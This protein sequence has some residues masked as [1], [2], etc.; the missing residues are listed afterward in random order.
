MPRSLLDIHRVQ[1]LC[2]PC[3]D[4]DCS[5]GLD[6]A[7]SKGGFTVVDVGH[8]GEITDFG[9]VSHGWGYDTDLGFGQGIWGV[10]KG[11]PRNCPLF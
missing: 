9:Y 5:G 4:R 7:I 6:Q 2:L 10:A 3:R 8:D 11:L 1:Q